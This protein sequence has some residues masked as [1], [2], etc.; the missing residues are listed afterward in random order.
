MADLLAI[1]A[2]LQ[3]EVRPV[4]RHLDRVQRI[5]CVGVRAWRGHGGDRE[6]VVFRTGVGPRPAET[7][8]RAVLSSLPVSALLNTG[9]AGALDPRL[10]TE[11]LVVPEIVLEEY[12]SGS[13]STPLATCD[14]WNRTLRRA[15]QRAALTLDAGPLVTCERALL[16]AEDKRKTGQRLGASAVDMETAALARVATESG[17]P[18]S[19]ARVILDTADHELPDLATAVGPDG[20][21]RPLGAVAVI[22][23][24]PSN[25]RDFLALARLAR[26]AESR[27]DRVFAT[28]FASGKRID[29]VV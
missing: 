12:D 2:A 13:R 6:V 25:I 5:D 28:V 26:A 8:L 16:T 3:W 22:A 4:L 19:C 21:I 23:R 17:I 18:F 15:A 29:D 14:E 24:K 10:T 7:A 20:S 1:A 9:C 27:L 11:T